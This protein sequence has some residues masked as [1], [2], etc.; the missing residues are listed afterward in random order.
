M[1]EGARQLSVIQPLAT[2]PGRPRWS[3][4]LNRNGPLVVITPC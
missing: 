3:G 4:N 2:D 1:S